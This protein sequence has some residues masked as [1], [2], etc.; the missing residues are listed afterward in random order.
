[1]DMNFIKL[2]KN[3]QWLSRVQ[4]FV[5]LWTGAHQA[6]VSHYLLGFLYLLYLHYLL[7]YKGGSDYRAINEN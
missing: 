5:T 7:E 4:L 2:W 1:M 3:V 6:F